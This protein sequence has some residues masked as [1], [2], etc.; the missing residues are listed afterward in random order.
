MCGVAFQDGP[1]VRFATKCGCKDFA[2]CYT[3]SWFWEG[4][5]FR[6]FVLCYTDSG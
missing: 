3:Y 1:F 5:G 4:L 6:D 2:L